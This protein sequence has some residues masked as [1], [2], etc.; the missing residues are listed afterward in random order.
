[1]FYSLRDSFCEA[2]VRAV[3]EESRED[4]SVYTTNNYFINKVEDIVWSCFANTLSAQRYF[5]NIFLGV[6]S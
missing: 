1:M 4:A 2:K 5:I 3:G 6:C